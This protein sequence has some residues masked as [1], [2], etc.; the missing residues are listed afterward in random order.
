MK[1][2]IKCIIFGLFFIE[3]MLQ[4]HVLLMFF[5]ASELSESGCGSVCDHMVWPLTSDSKKQTYG[6]WILFQSALY[7][8]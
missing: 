3:F 4:K 5:T 2:H 8:D 7:P 1:L 6:N